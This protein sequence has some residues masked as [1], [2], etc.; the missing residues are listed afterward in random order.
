MASRKLFTIV[1]EF[2]RPSKISEGV[3]SVSLDGEFDVARGYEQAAD[4]CPSDVEQRS[5]ACSRGDFSIKQ[6][7]YDIRPVSAAGGTIKLKDE[8]KLSFDIAARKET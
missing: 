7:D 2:P 1:Q 6:S 5:S 3:F 8:L 4:Y